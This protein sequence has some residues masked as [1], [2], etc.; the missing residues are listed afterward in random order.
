MN[1]FIKNNISYFNN[2]TKQTLLKLGYLSK[3][4]TETMTMDEKA[5]F[6][7]DVLKG[8]DSKQFKREYIIQR[9]YPKLTLLV[10]EKNLPYEW[11]L[12][13]I[14][15]GILETELREIDLDNEC[16]SIYFMHGI[17]LSN[18]IDIDE[19]MTFSEA[20]ERWALS[21]STLRKLVT[22]DRLV[23]GVDYRKSGK[24]WLIKTES[25]KK[26]YGEPK[27]R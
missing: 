8:L 26:I 4:I 6:T 3:K 25:M 16:Y 12:E 19:V 17:T 21:D 11:L 9:V 18:K 22:T 7:K 27:T 24:V 14:T 13:E 23:E 10:H 2:L 5:D 1:E 20:A 15:K